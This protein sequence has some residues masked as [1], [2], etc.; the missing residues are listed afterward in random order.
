V[1]DYVEQA[2]GFSKFS[3]KSLLIIDPN[4]TANEI[5]PMFLG[6]YISDHEIYPGTVILATREVGKV[7]GLNYATTVAPV[8]SS[9]AISLASLNSIVDS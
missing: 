2:G 5:K 9:L 1:S 6:K 4:G 7:R 3:D 8:I